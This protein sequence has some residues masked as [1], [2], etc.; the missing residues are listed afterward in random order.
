MRVYHTET[1]EDF[2]ALMEKLEREGCKWSIGHKPTEGTYCWRRYGTEM[3]VYVKNKDLTIGHIGDVQG[4]LLIEK[5]TKEPLYYVQFVDNNKG[6]LNVRS[7]GSKS[8]N[9]SVQND[10]FKTQFTE[11]E[12]KE[13]D[14]RYWQFA[15]LVDEVAE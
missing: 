5:Y 4:A 8:L 2:N 14:E 7:D 11:A 15:V 3:V 10:I 13:M 1:Q 9:N 12:I 6:Y